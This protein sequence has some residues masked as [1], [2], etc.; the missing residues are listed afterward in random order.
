MLPILGGYG[1]YGPGYNTG[2]NGYGKKKRK[3]EKNKNKKTLFL[4][5]SLILLYCLFQNKVSSLFLV[6]LVGSGT[7]GIGYGVNGVSVGVAG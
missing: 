7:Y 3:I 5:R 2:Y 1:T 4:Y 6:G